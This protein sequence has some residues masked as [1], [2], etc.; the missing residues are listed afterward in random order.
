MKR[1]P[2]LLSVFLLAASAALAEEAKLDE[3]NSTKEFK[4]KIFE[5]HSRDPQVIA[6]SVRLLGSGF[7]GAAL[8][9]NGQL[10]TITVRD[11]PENLAAIE[12]AI[13]RL[14]QP[15]A[16]APDVEL[17][18]WVLIGSKSPIENAPALPDDLAPVVNELRSTLRYSHYALLTAAVHRTKPGDG[19]DSSGIA[20]PAALGI[21]TRERQPI[22]YS[23][24]LRQL[25]VGTTG[26]RPA[27]TAE[28][29]RFTMKV[30]V[31]VGSATQYQ[32]V[33]FETPVTIRDKEKVVIGTTTM[34]DKALIVVVTANL[35]S[36]S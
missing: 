27:L 21:A 3:Y 9:V 30:P 23:Y 13:K 11:F 29:F 36:R 33:G 31:D 25:A 20:E 7:K 17:R 16:E 6:A 8:S 22:F 26:D 24:R 12:E 32:D 34:G 10:H 4:N 19:I 35:K 15:A 14:D 1:V 18:I 5:L 2:A 28:N